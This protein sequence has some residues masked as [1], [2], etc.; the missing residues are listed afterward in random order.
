MTRTDHT[1]RS[2]VLTLRGVSKCYRTASGPLPVLRRA[3]M[4]LYAGDFCVISGPSGSGKSTLLNLVGC[5]DHP[6]DGQ[7]CVDGVDVSQLADAQ[8]AHLRN[9]KIGFVFQSFHLIPVLTAAENVAYPL[10]LRGVAKGR[11]LARARELLGR[12]GLGDFTNRVPAKL[13]GG[14]RQRVAIARALACEPRVILADEPT[15]NLDRGTA[16]EVMDLLASLNAEDDVTLFI[17]THDPLVTERAT[18]HFAL[19]D[20]GVVEQEGRAR[21]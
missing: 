10:F 17:A 6:D 2:A 4:E 14:Q 20:G 5:L 16:G 18:R 11:R 21:A 9:T 13:S 19:Q 3:S 8:A 1:A 12:V 7:V 15:A